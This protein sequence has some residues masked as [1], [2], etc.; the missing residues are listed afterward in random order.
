MLVLY[1]FLNLLFLLNYHY[2]SDF[3]GTVIQGKSLLNLQA[4]NE[5]QV[6]R[7]DATI[8]VNECSIDTINLIL[9]KDQSNKLLVA[10]YTCY[11]QDLEA[12]FK[13]CKRRCSLSKRLGRCRGIAER[14]EQA[15]LKLQD[16]RNEQ[17][18]WTERLTFCI[19][20]R[21]LTEYKLILSKGGNI[22]KVKISSSNSADDPAYTPKNLVTSLLGRDMATIEVLYI[23]SSSQIYKQIEKDLC[24]SSS[25]SLCKCARK[26]L[27]NIN[28]NKSTLQGVVARNDEY[29]RRWL[30]FYGKNGKIPK[31]DAALEGISEKCLGVEELNRKVQ[32]EADGEYNPSFAPEELATA[33]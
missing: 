9:G 33:L 24:K 8:M 32:A 28:E 21:I 11:V 17:Q 12:T 25:K 4:T 27:K 29:H 16:Y 22:K 6:G 3:Q 30:S 23:T 13:R 5:P 31:P 15:K 26:S 10:A 20:C 7:K 19:E 2:F 14:L 18:K 1:F